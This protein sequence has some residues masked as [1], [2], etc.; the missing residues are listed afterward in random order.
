MP[1]TPREILHEAD[2]L[3]ATLPFLAGLPQPSKSEFQQLVVMDLARIAA[4]CGKADA[5]RDD[6][7]TMVAAIFMRYPFLDPASRRELE[8]WYQLDELT[9]GT[10]TAH[11]VALLESVRHVPATGFESLA[12][13]A[14]VARESGRS[15]LDGYAHG[16][17]A[18]AQLLVNADDVISEEE[19]NVL[20]R[21][22]Q[23]IAQETGFA[24]PGADA[25][26]LPK[27]S[28]AQSKPGTALPKTE[29][30]LDRTLADLGELIGLG[31]IK[32]L[33]T[34]LTNY[35]KIQNER[36]A[37]GLPVPARSLHSVFFGPPGTG[38]TTVARLCARIFKHLG[39][40]EKGHLVETDRSGL[41]SG[42]MGQTAAKVDE[43]VKEACGGVLFIDEAYTL[44]P[45][46]LSG[47]Y[48]REAIDTLMK[49]MEDLRDKFIVIAAGYT[50][51]MERFLT[52]NPG[53]R[54]RFAQY[55]HFVD[56]TPAELY[57]IFCSF[58]DRG[59]FVLSAEAQERLRAILER[60]H[61]C[62]D[63]TFGNG[64][65]VRN[66]F[67]QTLQ[68]QANRLASLAPLTPQQLCTFE[69]PDLPG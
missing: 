68:K 21:V 27:A 65:F 9:I 62:R 55:F 59:R 20:K 3:Y 25:A 12:V 40:L 6:Y 38:K 69:A 5:V 49:R 1:C 33:V 30:S 51:E 16:L 13:V 47:D 66:L 22:W 54:S 45:A 31:S 42:Y 53:V 26:A 17:Y 14:E 41:V 11:A 63:R 23:L 58:A 28:A 43:L 32:D 35:L 8:D 10:I 60:A 36:R 57:A 39:L 52:A 44:A 7:E 37:Q 48:G 2:V 19:Q 64:R 18:F 56:Y 24:D 67:E 50:D 4:L 34:G 15:I 46:G 61:A 29:D